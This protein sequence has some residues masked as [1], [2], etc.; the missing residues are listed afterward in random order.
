MLA[1]KIYNLNSFRRQ[2]E[3]LLTLSVCETI[4]RLVW[5]K[6][7]SDLL[8]Q[9][10]WSNMLSIA[11]LFSYC[12]ESKYLDAALRI[13]QTCL[14]Q[15]VTSENQKNAAAFILD[16]LTNKPAIKIALDKQY[17]KNNFRDNY[18]FAL[19]VQQSK[20][21]IEHT[22]IINDKIFLLNRFQKEVYSAYKHNETISIS[23]PTS[24]GKSYILCTLLLEE[25]TEGNKNIVYV[26]PT[27]ALISQVET[28][29]RALLKQYNLESQTNVTTVPPQ[30]DVDIEKS[31]I[32]VFTQER[33]HWFLYGNSNVQVDILIVD[34]AHKIEDGNRGILLQQKI[35]DVVKT[36]P[37]IKVFFSSPFTSNPEILLE[38]VINNSKKC[39][40]NTQFVAVNQNLLYVVQVPRKI[41]EWQ[42]QLCTIEKNIL[43]G[44]VIMADRPT[45][46]R[47]KVVHIAYQTLNRGGCLIYSNGAADA[48]NTASLLFNLLPEHNVDA[49]VEELIELVK[50]TIHAQYVLA[51]VLSKGIAFHYGNMPLLIR[52][53]IERLFSVGKIEYLICTSTLLEGVNL[54]AK[55]III[56]K[57]SRGKGNPLNQNDFWNLA[58]R[59]GRLGKEYSGNIF[60]IEPSKWDIQPE[61]NKTKQEI[62]RALN[63]VES[64]GDEL[65]DYIRRGA[66]RREAVDR[67]DLDAAFGYFYIRY[68]L[69]KEKALSTPFYDRLLQELQVV[70]SQV[71][72]PSSIVKKNPGISPLAQQS[73]YD[74]FTEHI[75]VI[76][77]LIPVYPNDSNAFEEY[78]SLVEIIGQTISYYPQQ[79]NA[80]RAI[81]L[82]NWMSGRPLSYLISKSYDSYMR[83]HYHKKLS[84]V[85]REVMD[86]VESFVRYQFAKDSSCYV[87][88]LRYVL[89]LNGKRDLLESIPQ[90]SLWL[91]FGVSQKTHLSLL[92]LGL[93][94]NT[95]LELTNYIISTEKSQEECL[96]WLRSLNLDELDLSPIM[97]EDIRKIL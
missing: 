65:L 37:R 57:P 3:A 29:L 93:S 79:L 8:S 30:D 9:I 5:N 44:Y 6:D 38:N 46:E 26:V 19:R 67:P 69:E 75:D 15:D 76:D 16:N 92:A 13:A 35:E 14:S 24:A 62:K 54:P 40:V 39:K 77:T 78:K 42:I 95:V 80:S 23:A 45:S 2:Y 34:E 90:L 50:K 11:S 68:V 96:A 33:L 21:D 85:I 72:L 52:S 97:V 59:A 66:P 89:E 63:I 70:Q 94:R 25:L 31:N 64:K 7:K 22:I 1:E 74:Y 49:E 20:S 87:D 41:K 88:I 36:N 91:E 48:E 56:R 47:H 83:K 71:T 53:E 84:E 86:N 32:F 58:G 4:P 27:R 17:L 55:S 10:D 18:P 43:L 60:C 51:R 28:D 61:P 81:L 12:D 82:I 73:L